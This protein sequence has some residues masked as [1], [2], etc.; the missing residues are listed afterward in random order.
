LKIVNISIKDMAGVGFHLSK[1]LNAKTLYEC[2][3]VSKL[4]HFHPYHIGWKAHI[5]KVKKLIKEADVLHINSPTLD[6]NRGLYHD[7]QFVEK[8]SKYIGKKKIVAHYHGGELN[9]IPN[10]N[11]F[12]QKMKERKIQ[13]FVSTPELL[14]IHP[15]LRWFPSPVNIF[16]RL[17]PPSKRDK[18][19]TLF[20]ATISRK[21]K[22][23]PFMRSI[24][25]DFKLINYEA[26][27][28]GYPYHEL[29]RKM[30]KAHILFNHFYPFYGVAAI[31]GATL[32]LVVLTNVS[33]IVK[34][35]VPECNF[36]HVN[37]ANIKNVLRDL[38]SK[39]VNELYNIGKAQ[40]KFVYKYHHDKVI[41]LAKEVYG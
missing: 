34:K 27:Y 14:K 33:K 23:A 36:I 4:P 41:E 21:R 8:L 30:S 10:V 9:N 20:H 17:S 6:L 12:F 13:C 3:Q 7:Y 28:G 32:G 22:D 15:Y 5:E 26:S 2:S 40:R 19:F 16:L 29:I 39:S 25:K 38:A 24:M 37:K 35:Y 31:E 11:K 18:R 1:L